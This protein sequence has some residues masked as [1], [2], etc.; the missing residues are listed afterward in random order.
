MIVTKRKFYKLRKN[1]KYMDALLTVNG[2][3][4][5][6]YEKLVHFVDGTKS[7][8]S[9]NY[10]VLEIERATISEK[11]LLSYDI[12]LKITMLSIQWYCPLREIVLISFQVQHW[13]NAWK[14]LKNIK[15]M[16]I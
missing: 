7:P 2:L 16:T 14:Y 10:Q 12:T 9:P 15:R 3:P 4:H 11:N 5:G 6:L 1:T 13:M 8:Y